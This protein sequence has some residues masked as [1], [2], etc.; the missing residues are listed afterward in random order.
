MPN[1]SQNFVIEKSANQLW[2]E[3]G[4]TL[5]FKDWL[6]REKK[7]FVNFNGDANVMMVNRPL[8]TQIK[9]TLSSIRESVGYKKEGE[10]KTVFGMNKNILIFLG[11]GVVAFATYK[12]IKARQ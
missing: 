2:R 8:N 11:L 6:N 3:S 10:G 9:D 5:S 7:K 1:M 4:T 12:F